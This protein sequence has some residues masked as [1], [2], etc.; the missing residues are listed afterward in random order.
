MFGDRS[1]RL[2]F[3][4]KSDALYWT[5][6]L[7]ISILHTHTHKYLLSARSTD[8]HT[9]TERGEMRETEEGKKKE[10]TFL[11]ECFFSSEQSRA[12]YKGVSWCQHTHTTH[13][14]VSFGKFF[15]FTLALSKKKGKRVKVGGEGGGGGRGGKRGET[16]GRKERGE[17]RKR[18]RRVFLPSWS[19]RGPLQRRLCNFQWQ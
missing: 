11:I 13:F 17:E 10:V 18:P 8:S 5:M 9:R 15:F 6:D 19:E 16:K 4:A 12:E 14:L 1:A 7:S 2:D 3:H